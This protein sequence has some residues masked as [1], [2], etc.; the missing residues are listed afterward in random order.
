M[1]E[2]PAEVLRQA[3][4]QRERQKLSW[5]EKIRIAEAV[6]DSALSLRKARVHDPGAPAS[7]ESEPTK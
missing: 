7:P 4:W 2:V 1:S 6:R 5:A 3:A